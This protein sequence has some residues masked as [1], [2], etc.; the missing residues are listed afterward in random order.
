M[1]R[2]AV[3]AVLL[4]SATARAEVDYEVV[5]PDRARPDVPPTVEVT[6]VDGP[7]LP[8]DKYVLRD[9]DAKPPIELHAAKLRGFAQGNET[10]ALAIVMDTWEMWVGNDDV[11]R[12]D[13]RDP[14]RLAS[15]TPGVLKPLAAAL[16]GVKFADAGPP[17]SLA[18]IVTYGDR[19]ALRVPPEPLAALSGAQLGSQQDYYGVKGAEMTAGIELALARLH[20]VTAAR[21]L[22]VVICDGH[23]TNDDAARVRLRAAKAAAAQDRVQTFAIIY[24]APLSDAAGPGNAITALVPGAV[25]VNTAEA[26]ASALATILAKLDDRYYLTF[27][28]WDAVRD[29][30][31]AWDGKPHHLVLAIDHDDQE[32][33]DVI[34]APAWRPPHPRSVVFWVLIAVAAAAVVAAG[35]IATVVLV[36]RRRRAAPASPPSAA[37]PVKTVMIGAGGDR[38]GSPVVGWL[39][40]LNGHAAYQTFRLRGG[41]TKIG[42]GRTGCDIAI[43]DGFM[44]TEHCQI[45]A[46]PHGFTLIDSRSTNGCYVND[47]RIDRHELVDNDLVTLGKTCLRFKSI[48]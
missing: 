35:A 6:V 36:R 43:D 11:I 17:G 9:A 27:P 20:D 39:V 34:L 37:V 1:A 24:K 21:K 40:P 47:H 30:G 29:V 15:R 3:I 8:Q 7:K 4:A 44:S 31:L 32:A 45:A 38:D 23:D 10:V 48:G 2:L 14:A 28:G 5:P 42:T 13:D 46:S 22:L 26:I 19:A 41:V 18:M 25:T 33:A 12:A 16:D